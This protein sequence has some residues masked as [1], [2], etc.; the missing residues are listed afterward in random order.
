MGKHENKQQALEQ[1]AEGLNL[2]SQVG[3]RESELSDMI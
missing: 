2:E 1:E 3:S